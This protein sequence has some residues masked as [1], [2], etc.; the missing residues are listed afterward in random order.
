MASNRL[1]QRYIWL[2]DTIFSAKAISREEID[3]RWMNSAYNYNHESHYGE[4]NFHRHREA[5]YE[6]FGIEIV[7]NHTSKLYSIGNLGDLK[8]NGIRAWLIDTFA[9]NNLVNLAG[10]MKNRIIFE[11]IPEGNRFLSTIVSAMKENRKI[12]LTYQG[13]DRPEPHSFLLDPY[14]LKVFRQRWYLIGKPEDHPEE[15]DPRVYA[16]D[17]AKEIAL[18]ELHFRFPKRFKAADFFYG[19]MGVDRRIRD[20]SDVRIRV[21]AEDAPYLRT[22]P[23]HE[24]QTECQRDDQ[25]SIFSYHVA[26]TYDFIQELR[27]FGPSLE[28]LQPQ[29]LRL[30]FAQ[31]SARLAEIYR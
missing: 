21:R 15:H 3:R 11:Q 16:L 14:C 8:D 1:F 6:I 31:E 29:S 5:I 19:Y 13:F 12:R 7:C 9:I 10:D 4:R 26:L 23:L 17:R 28:V 24:S 25:F 30:R 20:I 27:K 18:S 2:V 22:L